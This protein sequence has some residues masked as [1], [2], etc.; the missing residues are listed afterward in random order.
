MITTQSSSTIQSLPGGTQVEIRGK[1]NGRELLLLSA[2]LAFWLMCEGMIFALLLIELGRFQQEGRISLMPLPV[3]LFLMMGLVFWASR[4]VP[5]WRAFLWQ[6]GGKETLEISRGLL[7]T[8]RT[9]FGIGP[10][11]EYRTGQVQEVSVVEPK[12]HAL[13][14]FKLRGKPVEVPVTGR[15]SLQM[16]GQKPHYAGYGLE[17]SP[18]N[19]VSALIQRQLLGDLPDQKQKGKP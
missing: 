13:D 16:D 1:R 8:R 10:A 4:G 9:V 2:W 19:Q 3:T 15:I 17:T 12:K 5:A 14:F 6:L 11:R 7:K 18:A